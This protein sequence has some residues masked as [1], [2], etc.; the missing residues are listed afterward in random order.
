[1][2]DISVIEIQENQ[3]N[4]KDGMARNALSDDLLTVINNPI[5]INTLSAQYAQL[6][7]IDILPIQEGTGNPSPSNIRP[8]SGRS[9]VNFN[10]H[11][12]NELKPSTFV[13][14]GGTGINYT[15]DSNGVVTLNGS[16]SSAFFVGFSFFLKSGTYILSGCPS[17]G[18]INN[19]RQDIRN[20]AVNGSVVQN[21]ADTGEGYEFTLAEDL[22]AYFAIRIAANYSCNN[23][24]FYPMIRKSTLGNGYE[25][26]MSPTDL[27]FVLGQTIFGG[28][29]D[30][31]S[32]KL[33]V[34]MEN[35]PS[36]AGE[37]LPGE[38]I[39]DRDVYIPETTP[40]TGA[41][42]VYAISTPY[43][44]QLTGSQVELL[45]GLNNI[46]SDANEIMLIYRSGEVAT[47]ADVVELDKKIDE[48]RVLGH[49]YST[50]EHI[51]GT[52]IDNKP[53]YEITT[54]IANPILT[55]VG[56]E[57]YINILFSD[58]NITNPDTIFI[59]KAYE[60]R[61]NGTIAMLNYAD[62]YNSDYGFLVPRTQ[63]SDFYYASRQ[64]SLVKIVIVTRYT[65]TTD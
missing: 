27:T 57:Y 22:T 33:T 65:K 45:K 34:T 37:T 3:Y 20:N 6:T 21:I 63:S 35:I 56:S 48:S 44:I 13:T 47:L 10:V 17:G 64:P 30:I 53:L 46:I 49:V 18:G 62:I 29:I 60:V 7:L 54:E 59:E 52:W 41:Q 11:G 38:W 16:A 36:Y 31:E 2:S 19:Y 1:M 12:K 55:N 40:T 51:V 43:T 61:N 28:N 24:K 39:S 25:S 9:Y 14:A 26:Y 23:L 58:C 5:L 4:L 8:I 50:D 42:V 15:V 32:G